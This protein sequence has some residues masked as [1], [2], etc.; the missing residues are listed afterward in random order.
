MQGLVPVTSVYAAQNSP[1]AINALVSIAKRR[2][3]V[4]K[5]LTK[6]ADGIDVLELAKFLGGIVVCI[7]VDTQ[8]LQ[9]TELPAQAFG[10]TAILEEH[11]WDQE[12]RIVNPA[13]EFQAPRYAPV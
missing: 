3:Q 9:G 6:A 5:L 2:P 8:R 13:M 10:V 4:L 1:K 12:D 7:Q 11:F